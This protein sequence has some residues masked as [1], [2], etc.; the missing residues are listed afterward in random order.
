MAKVELRPH[1]NA[2]MFRLVGQGIE[3]GSDGIMLSYPRRG[4]GLRVW[5]RFKNVQ[6]QKPQQIDDTKCEIIGT[7]LAKA[8]SLAQR[9]QDPVWD[10]I[11]SSLEFFLLGH[12]ETQELGWNSC[13][14]LSAMAFERLL[15]PQQ[16]TAQGTAQA[17]A[18]LWAPYKTRTHR[19]GKAGKARP[20]S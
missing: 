14:M 15:E 11:A 7:R 1:L 2:S 19:G 3:A 16:R 8:L 13:I 17:F 12:A 9:T 20:P 5:T 18:K 6:F 4:N 10:A